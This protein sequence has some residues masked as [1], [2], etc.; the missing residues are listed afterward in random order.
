MPTDPSRAHCSGALS[1]DPAG[2]IARLLL[3]LRRHHLVPADQLH[4]RAAEGRDL[5]QPHQA[6]LRVAARGLP[7]VPR[8]APATQD[9]HDRGAGRVH[10]R[11]QPAV[12]L[13]GAA[14]GVLDVPPR[15]DPLL[16][17]LRAQ[18]RSRIEV[19]ELERDVPC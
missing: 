14:L 6:P 7:P 19:P 4:R 9:Q 2:A 8:A 13:A 18:R 16:H 3:R 11:L 12:R 1:G 5:R 10:G 17:Q 15:G